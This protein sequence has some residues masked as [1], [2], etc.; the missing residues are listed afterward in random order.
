MVDDF[1][2]TDNA[3]IETTVWAIMLSSHEAMN[4]VFK[5][6]YNEVRDVMWSDLTDVWYSAEIAAKIDLI[7]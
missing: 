7:M 5:P 1:R 2:N 4:L 6:D 3:W